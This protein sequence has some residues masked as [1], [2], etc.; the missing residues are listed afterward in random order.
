M[1]ELKDLN[2][3]EL[4]EKIHTAINNM[5]KPPVWG[6]LLRLFSSDMKPISEEGKNRLV[7]EFK[8][9]IKYEK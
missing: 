3:E 2:E 9:S 4:T 6:L 5:E 1:K 8:E 7:D